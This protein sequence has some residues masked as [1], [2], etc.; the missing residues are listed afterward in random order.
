MT[1]FTTIFVPEDS[2]FVPG[3][4]AAEAS[5]R[6]L[7]EFFLDWDVEAEFR[8]WPI[9][10]LI[11][12][13][14]AFDR[15]TCPRCSTLVKMRELVD[16]KVLWWYSTLPSITESGTIEVPCCGAEVAGSEI[17]FGG[18]A[19]FARYQVSVEGP[20]GDFGNVD[21]NLLS[22]LESVL[23]CSVRRIIHVAT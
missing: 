1:D 5:K 12:S 11:T 19:R 9:S 6:V 18:E 2:A 8:S 13:G 15:F 22:S 20:G 3:V 10:R 23:G 7:E 16:E 4:D 14:D 17:D 21:A